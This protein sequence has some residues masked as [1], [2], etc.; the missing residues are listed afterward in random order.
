MTLCLSLKTLRGCST[1]NLDIVGGFY[2]K[3]KAGP[4]EW[5]CNSFPETMPQ[6]KNGLIEV[7]RLGT[8]FLMIK[9]KVLEKMRREF[10]NIDYINPEGKQRC[11]FFTE[12]VVNKEYVPEDWYFCDRAREAG[13]KVYGDGKTILGHIGSAVYPL[14]G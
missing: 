9:R 1:H 5:V 14:Q 13:F 6:D 4:A 12:W 10:P 11:R 8:G 2:A 3:K 7:R